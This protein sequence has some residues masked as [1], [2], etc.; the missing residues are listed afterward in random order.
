MYI[1]RG[2]SISRN[3]VVSYM[4]QQLSF[5]WIIVLRLH[6]PA[7]LW[8]HA[9]MLGW[10]SQ[11]TKIEWNAITWYIRPRNRGTLDNKRWALYT[12]VFW[13][14]MYVHAWLILLPFL[15]FLAAIYLLPLGFPFWV[16]LYICFVHRSQPTGPSSLLVKKQWKRA[17]TRL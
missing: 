16:I 14:P 11:P 12:S 7:T 3:D 4:T 10:S 5:P 9:W 15:R 1:I 8:H 6:T 13:N 17:P 2:V